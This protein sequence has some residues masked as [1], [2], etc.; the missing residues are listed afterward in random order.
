MMY[1]QVFVIDSYI[2]AEKAWYDT[3]PFRKLEDLVVAKI[4]DGTLNVGLSSS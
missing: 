3:I 1:G 4:E 2:Y